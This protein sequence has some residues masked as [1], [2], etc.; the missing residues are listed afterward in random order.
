[1]VFFIFK[2]LRSGMVSTIQ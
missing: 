2:R 1:M